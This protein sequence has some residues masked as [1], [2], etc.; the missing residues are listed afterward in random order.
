MLPALTAPTEPK[1]KRASVAADLSWRLVRAEGRP[2]ESVAFEESVVAFFMESAA[3]LGVPKSVAA[4]YGICF[5]SPEPLSYSDIQTRMNLSAG[6][7]SQG[8][9]VLREV[10]ALKLVRVDSRDCMTPDIELRK[11]IEH[12]ITERLQKQLSAGQ[13]SLKT[14]AQTVPGGRSA[15]AT[16]LRDRIKALQSWHDKASAMLPFVRTALQL[17]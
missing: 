6:S 14:I 1:P 4:L 7:I 3:I 16:T 17:G 9:K 5:A 11:L 8:L 15:A 13:S 12:W 2:A 10:G